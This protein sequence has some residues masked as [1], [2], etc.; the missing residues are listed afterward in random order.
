MLF[1]L[2]K[3]REK[4][5]VKRN[6]F[7]SLKWVKER[8]DTS[9]FFGD[10]FAKTND[11]LAES[12]STSSSLDIAIIAI[13]T[14]ELCNNNAIFNNDLRNDNPLPFRFSSRH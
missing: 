14:D 8:L 3:Q 2:T 9:S 13:F 1:L 7:D 12:V 5:I 10:I 6:E 4:Y 11:V